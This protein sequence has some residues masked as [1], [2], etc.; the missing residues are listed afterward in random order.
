MAKP[1]R[2]WGVI[3]AAGSG[4]RL[5]RDRPKQYL[6]LAG[7]TVIEWSLSPFLACDWVD[8]VVVV[9]ARGDAEFQGLPLAGHRKVVTT[10]GGATRAESVLRG[11]Q[12]IREQGLGEERDVY[13]MVH[14]AARPCLTRS[15]LEHLREQATGR[16][17]GLLAVPVTDTLKRET[18]G[19]VKATV[20]R[21]GLW[22][23]QTPQMFE[24]GRLTEALERALAEGLEITDEA[25]AMERS[26]ARPRLVCGRVSNIKITYAE[27]LPL[28]EFWLSQP[29]AMR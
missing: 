1:S 5:A 21:D 12:R 16:D 19:T 7:R 18:V 20:S 24:L 17:G 6:P 13:A 29:E 8:G 10:L 2:F 4:S 14:D 25:S 11:L 26:G 3:A 23:A 27:D 15:A 9:L 22:R 28:A